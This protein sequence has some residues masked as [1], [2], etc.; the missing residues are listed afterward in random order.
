MFCNLG[1]NGLIKFRCWLTWNVSLIEVFLSFYL[2]E[3]VLGDSDS[4]YT[5]FK[6]ETSVNL[7]RCGLK[8]SYLA[9]TIPETTLVA[10]NCF[11]QF[12]TVF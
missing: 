7:G 9:Y 12:Y 3:V 1:N 6:E 2:V 11:S 4:A 10:L 8:I 5:R